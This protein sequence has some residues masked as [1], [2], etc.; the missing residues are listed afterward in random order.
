MGNVASFD[1]EVRAARLLVGGRVVGSQPPRALPGR[2]NTETAS[3]DVEV[4]TVI[5]GRETR[6]TIRIWDQ[7]V[8]SS[9]SMELHRLKIGTLLLVVLDPAEERL[10]DL[11]RFVGIAPKRED[12]VLGTCGEHWRTF[13]TE[14]ELERYVERATRA[15]LGNDGV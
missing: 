12:Y 9:C 5:R 14:S 10:T 6:R 15:G 3:I 11:W 2:P 1:N 7:F 4:L 13:G 8:G